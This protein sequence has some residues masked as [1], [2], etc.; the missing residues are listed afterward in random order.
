MAVIVWK[1]QRKEGGSKEYT[2]AVSYGRY[3]GKLSVWIEEDEHGR[4]M[5]MYTYVELRIMMLCL[6]RKYV[7]SALLVCY[8]LYQA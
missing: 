2:S 6:Y 4:Y 5:Y 1:H 8:F 3:G 7:D